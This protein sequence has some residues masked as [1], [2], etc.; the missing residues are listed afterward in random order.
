MLRNRLRQHLEAVYFHFFIIIRR[1]RQLHN[2]IN[3]VALSD[4]SPLIRRNTCKNNY[5]VGWSE[6]VRFKHFVE[7]HAGVHEILARYS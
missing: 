5:F 6:F 7:E 3:N 2:T 1:A 4:V